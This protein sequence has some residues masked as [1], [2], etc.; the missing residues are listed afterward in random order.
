MQ[1]TRAVGALILRLRSWRRS[2]GRG[3]M[4]TGPEM[5]A[6]LGK[7]GRQGA[8]QLGR[9]ARAF[10]AKKT[11]AWGTTLKSVWAKWIL[12][13]TSWWGTVWRAL[14]KVMIGAG[15]A[16]GRGSVWCITGTDKIF[17]WL[18]KQSLYTNKNSPT[19]IR[20]LLHA[21]FPSY[22]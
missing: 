5:W 22:L 14:M 16:G 11:C 1:S 21:C 7:R 3:R 20:T 13:E 10:G 19:P 18:K 8:S 15:W 6:G 2:Q 9:T 12:L 4:W 17:F